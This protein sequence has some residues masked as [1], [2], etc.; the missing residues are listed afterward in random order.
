MSIIPA[1]GR[2][3][4]IEPKPAPFTQSGLYGL[5]VTMYQDG[6]EIATCTLSPYISMY[7][8]YEDPKL[9]IE[10]IVGLDKKDVV[11]SLLEVMGE[12]IQT[13][14]IEIGSDVKHKPTLSGLNGL[15]DSV[16]D[17]LLSLGYEQKDDSYR[18]IYTP[19]TKIS[20]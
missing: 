20:D 17:A 14:A 9:K 15:T 11:M 3:L 5:E 6:Q 16:K 8:A 2:Y 4:E 1:I 10:D 18:K 19:I 12:H 13:Q 7:P